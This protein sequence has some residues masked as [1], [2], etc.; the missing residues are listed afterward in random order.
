MATGG[1]RIEVEV[2]GRTLSLS[3]LGK[4]F[5]P[6][7]GFTKGDVLDYY[8]RI[9]PVALPHLAGRPLTLKRYPD[10]VTGEHFYEKNCPS[11]R[12][13]WVETAEIEGVRYCVVGDLA[14]L[15]WAVNLADLELHVPLARAEAIG[16]PDSVVFDLDPGEP[17]G[18][19]ECC[20]VAE[21]VRA[22]LSDLGLESFAKVSGAKGLQV[23][24]PLDAGMAGYGRT[25]RL[26]RAIAESLE[27]DRPALVVS[28]MR[29]DLR[30]GKV[31][32]DWSQNDAHKTTVCAYSLRAR[33]RPTVSLPV[34]WDEV[35]RGDAS[36]LVFS[37]DAALRRVEERGD[38][39]ASVL[40]LR[41]RLPDP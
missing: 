34:S 27:D 40:S 1:E 38:L 6:S 23:Y 10:G 25:K 35:A 9:A 20:E 28:R 12:P 5:Y 4:V 8:V 37:P 7:S 41:Q 11:H 21:A 18:L 17:A 30:R 14:S 22:R 29:K 33:E 39:F 16:R 31:F 24:A 3:N 19:A 36:R 13:D 15:V 2:E 32:V 26:A